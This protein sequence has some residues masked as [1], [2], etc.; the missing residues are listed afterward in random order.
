MV[1][2]N[3]IKIIL[4]LFSIEKQAVDE[5]CHL[6]S[7]NNKKMK[8]YMHMISSFLLPASTQQS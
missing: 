7:K 6:Q 8:N 3:S 4:S 5:I 2:F 1:T